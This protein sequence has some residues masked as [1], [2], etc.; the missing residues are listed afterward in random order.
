MSLQVGDVV[1]DFELP[2]Q[3]GAPRKLSEFLAQ[4]PTVVFF[5]PKASSPVCT[6]QACQFRDLGA[7]FQA[8]AREKGWGSVQRVGISKDSV[9]GQAG[10]VS[11]RSLDYP[12]L[13]DK[14]GKAA[15]AFGVKGGLGGLSP[16][17][18]STFVLDKDG[19]VL[20][21]IFHEFRGKAHADEA[22]EFLRSWNP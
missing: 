17:K 13:S 3:T 2:D 7:Q 1:P 8:L 22:L 4:G 10:F 21:A 9:S 12:L 15:A 18:R 6:V 19:K 16:V 11:G 14:E 20:K 5:Y